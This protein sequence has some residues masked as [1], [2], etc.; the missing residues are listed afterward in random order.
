[1]S[2]ENLLV[3]RHAGRLRKTLIAS[4]ARTEV[5]P[6]ISIAMGDATGETE[7]DERWLDRPA[8]IALRDWL[9]ASL[10][11]NRAEGDHGS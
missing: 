9:D 8:A 1:M 10:R 4:E 11:R 5:G 7:W 2:D 3:L 6:R